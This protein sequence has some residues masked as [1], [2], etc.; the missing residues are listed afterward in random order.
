MP[1]IRHLTFERFPKALYG[2]VVARRAGAGHTLS[3]PVFLYHLFSFFCRVLAPSVTV[4][5]SAFRSVRI[6]SYRHLQSVLYQ[7]LRLIFSYA[8]SYDT[9]GRNIYDPAHIYL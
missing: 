8:P 9:S 2:L 6:P 4:E 1:D 5:H 3:E 7:P